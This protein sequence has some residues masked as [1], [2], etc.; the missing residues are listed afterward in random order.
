MKM[1][2]A[3]ITLAMLA[4]VLAYGQS[5]EEE[6]KWTESIRP[7]YSDAISIGL[8]PV[9]NVMIDQTDG[10]TP[11][12]TRFNAETKTCTFVV[13]I[14]NNR[15]TEVVLANQKTEKEKEIART[16][17]FAH[18]YGHCLKFLNDYTAKKTDKDGDQFYS[19]VKTGEI[20]SETSREEE[21]AADVYA[22]AW[23]AQNRPKD[24]EV[25]YNFLQ[26]LRTNP[27]LTGNSEGENKQDRYNV[28][29]YILKAKNLVE[30]YDEKDVNPFLLAMN[31]VENRP[32]TIMANTIVRSITS[33][34]NSSAIHSAI[35][36]ANTVA[37]NKNAPPVRLR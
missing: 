10:H 11:A 23:F 1:K 6:N 5:T 21:G 35:A 31:I 30:V 22:L 17:I 16:A 3:F 32:Q 29:E 13:A 9:I 15:A 33:S 8:K 37:E 36:S 14:R 24:F 12:F 4:P 26:Y 7:F 34:V 28:M 20:H 25:A 2:I 27:E 19:L 18:E